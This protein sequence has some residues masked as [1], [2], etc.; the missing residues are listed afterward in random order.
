MNR[1]LNDVLI[2]ELIEAQKE[3]VKYQE[4]AEMLDAV[5]QGVGSFEIL[6]IKPL[7]I[8]GEAI[9]EGRWNRYYYPANEIEIGAPTL[10]GCPIVVD[11]G[12]GVKDIVGEVTESIWNKVN[13]KLIF[14]GDIINVEISELIRRGLVRGVS[15][16][17]EF[18]PINTGKGLTVSKIKFYELALTTHPACPNGIKEILHKDLNVI[19]DK[20]NRGGEMED[21][22]TEELS[23][24]PFKSYPKAD[25]NMSWSFTAADGNR[26]IERGGMSLF[27]RAHTWFDAAN[28]D[29]KGAYKLPHHKI[30]GVGL[31][32]IWRGVA[33][34]MAV[35]MGARGGVN[36]PAAEK[37]SAYNHLAKHYREFDKEPPRF[38]GALGELEDESAEGT[39]SEEIK[40]KVMAVLVPADVAK[41]LSE[42]EGYATY[43]IPEKKEEKTEDKPPEK[44]EKKEVSDMEK[45]PLKEEKEEKEE[46]AEDTSEKTEDKEEKQEAKT[47]DKEEAGTEEKVTKEKIVVSIEGIKDLEEKIESLT[48]KLNE[49]KEAQKEIKKTEKDAA[50]KEEPEEKEDSEEKDVKEPTEKEEPSEEKKEAKVIKPEDISVEDLLIEKHERIYPEEEKAE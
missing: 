49:M 41:K 29:N 6:S 47:E 3:I 17:A 48:E 2:D 5:K 31:K 24:V 15:I 20:V 8:R 11:H 13:K 32:T 27:K 36:I 33:A 34:A 19:K 50:K 38:G 28:A 10:K 16:G 44:E 4:S 39:I 30:M 18:E 25:M 40:E 7:R 21:K 43:N 45:E 1:E 35:L 22:I 23:V 14:E 42:E 9:K 37:K 12:K 46:K 26:L